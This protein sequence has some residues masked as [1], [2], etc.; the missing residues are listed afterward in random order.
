[1][2]MP[3]VAVQAVQENRLDASFRKLADQINCPP[4]LLYA[5]E[6]LVRF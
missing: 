6:I 2:M 5:L 4:V 1:M 3:E